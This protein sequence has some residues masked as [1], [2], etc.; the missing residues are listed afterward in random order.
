MSP[1]KRFL[2]VMVGALLWSTMASAEV[3]VVVSAQNKAAAMSAAQVSQIFLGKVKRFPEG[4]AVVP[5]DQPEG[6]PMRDAF[7][8]RFVGK[9]ADQMKAYW[10]KSIFTGA[11]Q[12]PK[13]VPND[14]E[15]KRRLATD[16][17]AIGY[18][19]KSSV[20]QSVRIVLE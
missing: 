18:V 10:S 7:Y 4:G 6:S 20:D 11:G 16:P 5:V 15:V 17:T 3:V 13:E 8:N 1:S 9:N 14:A 12:P 19:D 2:A